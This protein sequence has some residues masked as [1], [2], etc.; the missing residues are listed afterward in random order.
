[1]KQKAVESLLIIRRREVQLHHGR[2]W[3]VL[4]PIVINALRLEANLD[5]RRSQTGTAGA[6]L[7]GEGARTSCRDHRLDQRIWHIRRTVRV[8]WEGGVNSRGGPLNAAR[9]ATATSRA[10]LGKRVRLLTARLGTQV[11]PA[12]ALGPS[13]RQRTTTQVV[14]EAQRL[15]R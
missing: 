11:P 10:M 12:R 8:I 3:Y 5:E 2:H 14:V 13:R 15:A 6:H 9:A 7:E 4:V 1:M